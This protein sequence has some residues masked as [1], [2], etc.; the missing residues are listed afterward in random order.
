[1][2]AMGVPAKR[3]RLKRRKVK[4]GEAEV[5]QTYRRKEEHADDGSNGKKRDTEEEKS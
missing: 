2:L 4:R 5:V 1:M 3:G